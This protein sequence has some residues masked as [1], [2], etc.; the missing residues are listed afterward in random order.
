MPGDETKAKVCI[1]SCRSWMYL[2]KQDLQDVQN[3]L[4]ARNVSIEDS[5][6][7]DSQ[8]ARS[9]RRTVK[10]RRSA[11]PTAEIFRSE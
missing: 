5:S 2:I 3:A 6:P 1:L 7:R 11:L 4:G 9:V 8:S 10:R